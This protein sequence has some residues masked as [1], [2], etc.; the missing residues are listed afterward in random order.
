VPAVHVAKLKITPHLFA[1]GKPSTALGAN[2][3]AQAA[4]ASAAAGATPA[5][6]FARAAAAGLG[7]S[8]GAAS[9]S[10]SGSS[11][12]SGRSSSGGAG[13]LAEG[14]VGH[15]SFVVK[16]VLDA[17]APSSVDPSMG[18]G[19]FADDDTT[20]VRDASLR[21]CLNPGRRSGGR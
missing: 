12:G 13:A 1:P 2:A 17:A 8:S 14:M 6:P 10:S 7:G 19:R 18:G 16:V 11:S 15:G 21:H 20:E 9:A 5:N 3:A 4:M